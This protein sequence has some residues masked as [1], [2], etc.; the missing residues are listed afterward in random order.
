MRVPERS[1]DRFAPSTAVVIDCEYRL[2]R[3]DKR[4]SMRGMKIDVDS[5]EPFVDQPFV[6]EQQ[7]NEDSDTIRDAIFRLDDDFV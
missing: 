6:E 7:H 5:D 2:W 3:F 4:F 1:W